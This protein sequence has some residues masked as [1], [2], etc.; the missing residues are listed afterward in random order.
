MEPIGLEAA[1]IKRIFNERTRNMKYG[2]IA[3]HLGH[4][5]SKE[6]HA[7]LADYEYELREIPKDKLGEFMLSRD[8]LAINVTI[9]YKED[10]IPYLDYIDEAA[11]KMNAVNTIVNKDGKLYGYNTDFFGL[12]ALIDHMGLDLYGK[13]V[14]IAGTGGTAKTATAVSTAMGASSI[15][16]ISRSGREGTITYEEAYE[17]HTDA[18]VIIN[19]TPLG[20]FNNCED[21]PLDVSKFKNLCGVVDA[22][23]NPLRTNLV[24]DA[25]E[26]GI[27][28]LGGLYMLVA[29]AVLAVE[30][31]L[32]KKFKDGTIDR[33]YFDILREKENIVLIGMPGSGKS[34]IGRLLAKE[35]DRPFYDID[36][37]IV[38]ETGLSIPEI[39]EKF[40]EKGFR[41]IESEVLAK[42]VSK[43]CSAVISTG[44]GAILREENV[45]RL[46]RGG[47]LYFL[48]RPLNDIIPTPDRPLA[49]SRDAISERYRE[50]Y[51][52]Y[53]SLADKEIVWDGTPE[54]ATAK[55]RKDFDNEDIYN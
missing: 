50:R 27:N 20:M 35:L 28:A 3:E 1:R 42:T 49:L 10:V 24:L 8:F 19:T 31:F 15:C 26:R 9:P 5:Y 52:I 14:L 2:L 32:D 7:R 17:L 21:T 4:S 23:Y 30:I 11:K 22:V 47:R 12:S 54:D 36:E 38:N 18:D 39:F 25:T 44:G 34:T 40:G 13:K 45:R 33:V 51:P 46:R 55:I 48:N 29:Q 41:D 43:T 6:I 16:K 37:C 53:L